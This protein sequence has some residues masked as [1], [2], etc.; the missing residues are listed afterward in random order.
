MRGWRKERER[1]RERY[2]HTIQ[3]LGNVYVCI[4]G[5]ENERVEVEMTMPF[6]H[7]VRD[8][9]MGSSKERRGVVFRC[10]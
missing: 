10:L 8:G 5:H 2:V 4:T 9:E 3:H 7:E 1:G 6:G